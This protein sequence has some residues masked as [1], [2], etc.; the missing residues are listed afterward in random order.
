VAS[1]AVSIRGGQVPGR[2]GIFQET[3]NAAPAGRLRMELFEAIRV[4]PGVPTMA[5]QAGPGPHQNRRRRRKRSTTNLELQM[6][7]FMLMGM[8]LL[9]AVPAFA[10]TTPPQSTQAPTTTATKQKAQ[11][12]PNCDFSVP[13]SQLSPD[14]RN[15]KSGLDAAKPK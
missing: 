13:V 4:A 14:C 7:T 9:M 1:V 8:G 5:I 15:I 11:S 6:K 2:G 10:Q 3:V 12:G